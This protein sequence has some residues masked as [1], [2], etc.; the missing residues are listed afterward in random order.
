MMRRRAVAIALGGA[1]GL[2]LPACSNVQQALESAKP[3]AGKYGLSGLVEQAQKGTQVSG[4]VLQSAADITP[5]QEYYIGRGVGAEIL[6]NPKF[7]ESRRREIEEYVSSVGQAIALGA[8][9]VAIPY[10]GYRFVLLE[11]ATV[12]AVSVPGGYVFI[13]TGAVLAARDEEELAGVLAHEIAHVSLKHGL[14]AIKQ[15]NLAEAGKILA[16]EAAK[17]SSVQL[18]KIYGDSISEVFATA[19]TNGYGRAQELAA[20]QAA[21]AT[22]PRPGTRAVACS[23]TCDGTTSTAAASGAITRRRRSAS[24]R[25]RSWCRDGPS[26]RASP[27]GRR[28]SRRTCPGRRESKRRSLRLPDCYCSGAEAAQIVAS[29]PPC[30]FAPIRAA[31]RRS[32]RRRAEL[33]DRVQDRH[34]GRLRRR[35]FDAIGELLRQHVDVFL[36][37]LLHEPAHASDLPLVARAA[38]AEQTRDHVVR[39]EDRAGAETGVEGVGGGAG[40]DVAARVRVPQHQVG[41]IGA[42]ELSRRRGFG[43]GD[44]DGER[45][46]VERDGRLDHGVVLLAWGGAGSSARTAWLRVASAWYATSA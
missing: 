36:L 35:P 8:P 14:A 15:S 1:A 11:S 20:D 42:G 26:H 29:S 40:V 32:I 37:P 34:V 30:V 10:Q 45:R 44:R 31:Q 28:D 39:S 16:S 4:L 19:V 9:S 21:V 33:H 7:A 18:A 6:S 41:E 17:Q 13:T 27:C 23:S 43:D 38:E 22:S 2:L 12:N 24:P 3:M 46:G 25:S 5:D